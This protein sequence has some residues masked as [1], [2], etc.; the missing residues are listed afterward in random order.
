ME[1]QEQYVR[2]LQQLKDYDERLTVEL[3][4][5]A[6]QEREKQKLEVIPLPCF[7]IFR[8]PHCLTNY[9]M[10]TRGNSRGKIFQ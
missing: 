4:A 2:M 10:I 7:D 9:E 8:L 1:E 3:A 5:K 6:F